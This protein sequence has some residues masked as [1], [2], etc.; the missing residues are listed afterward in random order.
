M[1]TALKEWAVMV[2]GLGCGDIIGIVRKGGLRDQRG[3]FQMRHSRFFLYPTRFHASVE[4]LSERFVPRLSRSHAAMAPHGFVR[5][6]YVAQ[7]AIS[8]TVSDCRRLVAARHEL[9]LSES[10]LQSR[11][12]YREPGAEFHALRIERLIT[13][14]VIPDVRRYA[15]CV[16][17]LELDAP[18]ACEKTDLAPVMSE[19]EFQERLMALVPLLCDAE[20]EVVTT[21]DWA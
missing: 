6:E 11:F 9:A 10:A 3:G 17:W 4:Q 13:P 1:R 21:D 20:I 5:I 19:P 7:P 8:W 2:D 18:I 15:G 12:N 14:V 16:S